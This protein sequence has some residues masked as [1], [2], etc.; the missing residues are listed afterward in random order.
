MNLP[1][2]E[3]GFQ[4]NE[5]STIEIEIDG[6][7]VTDTADGFLTFGI[8]ENEFITFGMDFDGDFGADVDSAA[9]GLYIAPS[10]G[11]DVLDPTTLDPS[12]TVSTLISD[13]AGTSSNVGKRTRNSVSSSGAA[14][15]DWERLTAD[16]NG[17]N[18]PLKFK[19]I[20]NDIDGTFTFEFSS[21]SI[22]DPLSC[23][24]NSVSID[25]DFTLNII[26]DPYAKREEIKITSFDVTG[27]VFVMLSSK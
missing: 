8:G 10:C 14:T 11:G 13:N 7:K 3:Y 12:R 23:E 15:G 20:N 1:S 17:D 24:Y 22:T 5:I 27:Y 4:E 19:F 21:P 6:A 9:T 26:M 18:F 2:A 25:E 16:S